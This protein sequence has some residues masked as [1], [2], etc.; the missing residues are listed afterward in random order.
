MESDAYRNGWYLGANGAWDGKKQAAGWKKDAKGWWYATS[1]KSYLKNCWK[2]INGGWYYFAASGYAAQGEFIQGW[3][4]NAKSCCCTYPYRARWH[5]N[6]R[7]W[8]Y[9]DG[10]GWYAKHGRQTIDGVKYRFDVNGY[11]IP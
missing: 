1:G 5:K 2:K 10:S 6:S 4:L 7:G 3:W 8:W 11:Y 9:G